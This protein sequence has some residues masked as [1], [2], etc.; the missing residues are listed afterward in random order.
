MA[1]DPSSVPFPRSKLFPIHGVA[2]VDNEDR[3]AARRIINGVEH[4]I[5]SNSDAVDLPRT[6]AK[7][8]TEFLVALW[9]WIAAQI[10][11]GIANARANVRCQRGEGLL[12]TLPN[13]DAI[14]G[15]ARGPFIAS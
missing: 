9:A 5:L 14:P 11:Q 13:V 15:Q 3:E 1:D 2:T 7:P 4:P 10:A 12:S 8:P 6:D